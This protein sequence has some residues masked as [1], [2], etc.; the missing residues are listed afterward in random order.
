MLQVINFALC[1]LRGS[2]S[3]VGFH[4]NKS[5][6]LFA[7]LKYLNDYLL[8]LLFHKGFS[9]RLEMDKFLLRI[10]LLTVGTRYENFSP[11][12]S[13]QVVTCLNS[14]VLQYSFT[15]LP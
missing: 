12:S 10:K 3:Y 9:S 1:L 8:S 11:F 13:L 7:L 6:C 2:S 14:E 15:V 4:K 5:V